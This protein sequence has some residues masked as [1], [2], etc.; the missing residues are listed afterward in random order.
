MLCWPG[1][2]PDANRARLRVRWFAFAARRSA[3]LL[4]RRRAR[5]SSPQANT[6]PP[7]QRT[8]GDACPYIGKFEPGTTVEMFTRLFYNESK[9]GGDFLKETM[10]KRFFSPIWICDE[11]EAELER[12]EN[13][14]WRLE[15]ISGFRK[16]KFVKASPKTTKYFFTCSLVKE[17]GMIQTEQL[18][19]REY[20]ATEISG[21]FIEGLKTTSV[22]RITR[23]ADLL[24]RKVYRNI[25]LRHL[26]WQYILIGHLF[27]SI[28]VAG[29]IL[30]HIFDGT[31]LFSPQNII[32][33]IVGICSTS[34]LFY[35]LFGWLYLR[36]Q[37]A[38]YWNS[39]EK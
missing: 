21:N 2:L 32:F 27:S 39:N 8:V 9:K 3:S 33:A 16:F 18:L 6:Q 28:S 30:S 26:V 29:I 25:Y 19:K 11:I 17:S 37:Y 7:K 36:K 35:H 4:A 31:P 20:K 23:E 15:K 14:G 5:E 34:S 1:W 13:E 22:Y 10:T 24:Q 12:L 38:K